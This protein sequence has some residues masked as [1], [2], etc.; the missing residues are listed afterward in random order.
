MPGGLVDLWGI[1][2]RESKMHT[3][4]EEA[5]N[6]INSGVRVAWV[7]PQADQVGGVIIVDEG[8][9][10]VEVAERLNAPTPRGGG[11]GPVKAVIGLEWRLGHQLQPYG[12]LEL[13]VVNSQA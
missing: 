7:R 10:N 6:A 11:A 5:G 12:A 3:Y 9:P 8:A 4:L 1:W 13:R 2:L